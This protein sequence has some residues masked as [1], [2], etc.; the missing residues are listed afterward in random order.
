MCA[1]TPPATGAPHYFNPPW[2]RIGASAR[3][4]PACGADPHIIYCVYWHAP[5]RLP[6]AP[7]ECLT[8]L[9]RS[10]DIRLGRMDRVYRPGDKVVGTA[11]VIVRGS[12]LSHDGIALSADGSAS[13]QLSAKSVGL[14]EA[15]YS[16][17]KPQKLF[18][19]NATLAP[20]GKL[21]DGTHEFDFE[22]EVRGTEGE[23][24]LESYH[25]V[26]INTQYVITVE[27]RRGMLA[28]NLKRSVEF[29]VEV[30]EPRQLKLQPMPF[31]IVPESLENVRKSAL[32]RIPTFKITGV[33]DSVICS[34]QHPLSGEVIVEEC[35]ATIKSIE[36]QLV[37][38]ETC[39]YADG[40]ARE[41]TEIQNIQ[42]ADGSV[43]Q[44]WSIPIHMVF[45]RLFTCPT[46]L[47]R[48]FKVEFE[49]NLVILFSDGHLLTENFP[50]KLLR[51][52]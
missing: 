1:S 18:G 8:H 34:I 3:I 4:M 13:L 26:Y 12:S 23:K 33:L 43:C 11:V 20:T 28:K 25:G 29:I 35:S 44:G 27:V 39:S 6:H 16:T 10:I 40:M 9:Y 19:F 30:P 15:F 7:N 48:T 24:L 32:S 21:A 50:L 49:V 52:A 17:I 45:P 14:F 36:L 22:F 46:V 47:T 31:S 42:I 38:V 51:T 37:R 2:S 5:P 41:A